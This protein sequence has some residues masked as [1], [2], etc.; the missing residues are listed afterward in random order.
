MFTKLTDPANLPGWDAHYKRIG[1]NIFINNCTR[2]NKGIFT[3]SYAA[4]N[5][6][7]GSQ[8]STFFDKGGPVFIFAF[9]LSTR[10]IDVGKYHAWA[11]KYFL[12]ERDV[13]V[14][15]DVVLD[16]AAVTNNNLV[17]DKYVLTKRNAFADGGATTDMYEVP[18]ARSFADAGAFVYDGA[19]VDRVAHEGTLS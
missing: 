7:V 4:D 17:A 15:A 10:V 2:S 19:R 1:G 6:A 3:Y 5:G 8:S 14:N 16:F 18:D 13:I 12:F 11:A 9:N